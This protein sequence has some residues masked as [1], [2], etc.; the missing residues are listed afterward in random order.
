MA[1]FG[2][3][4]A[5]YADR[6]SDDK[7]RTGLNVQYSVRQKNRDEELTVNVEMAM[8]AQGAVAPDWK[9]K[10]SLQLSQG[11]LTAL[12]E[13]MFGLR[14]QAEFSFHGPNRNKGLKIFNN[15][16]RGVLLA[17]SEAGKTMQHMLNHSQRIEL[18]VFVIRRQAMAWKISV[19]DVLA[20]LRQSVAISRISESS[21]QV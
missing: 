8:M 6:Q 19:S 21:D 16:A 18:G 15:N 13:V 20:V 3:A 9:N 5:F 1:D 10:I 4:L 11:E 7:K 2:E 17:I 12:C 14:K